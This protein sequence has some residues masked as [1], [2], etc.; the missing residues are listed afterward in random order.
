M[1]AAER[2]WPASDIM[3][4]EVGWIADLHCSMIAHMRSPRAERRLPYTI[5]RPTIALLLMT[6]VAPPAFAAIPPTRDPTTVGLCVLV[7]RKDLKIHLAEVVAPSSDARWD[8]QTKQNV[9]DMQTPIP[10]AWT[11]NFWTP[12]WVGNPEVKTSAPRPPVDCS[13]F[14]RQL[15]GMDDCRL[16]R[17]RTK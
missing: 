13:K 2:A 12:L 17:P 8:E 15:C 5:R 10:V 6:A 11:S 7:G 9:L 1:T 16:A 14:N 4:D 3:N